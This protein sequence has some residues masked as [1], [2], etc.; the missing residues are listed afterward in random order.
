[1]PGL[2]NTVKSF[3]L[4]LLGRTLCY[5]TF[6]CSVVSLG[7]R[8]LR[9]ILQIPGSGLHKLRAVLYI[10]GKIGGSSQTYKTFSVFFLEK[11]FRYF[12]PLQSFRITPA[13]C[14]YS[15]RIWCVSTRATIPRKSSMLLGIP[16]HQ[17]PQS[18]TVEAYDAMRQ[19]PQSQTGSSK[20]CA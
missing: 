20:A 6:R 7:G 10:Q 16:K 4:R 2:R 17:F 13:T 8:S 14:P 5:S 1:M 9:F 12:I 19:P 11:G 3:G 15:L 18:C